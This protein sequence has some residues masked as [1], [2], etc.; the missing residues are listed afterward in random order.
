MQIEETIRDLES[1]RFGFTLRYARTIRPERPEGSPRWPRLFW[2][3]WYLPPLNAKWGGHFQANTE[4]RR[5]VLI[6]VLLG[7][8]LWRNHWFKLTISEL[9]NAL[10]RHKVSIMQKAQY[11]GNRGKLSG[12][13]SSRR[14]CVPEPESHLIGPPH[15]HVRAGSVSLCA[16]HS[17]PGCETEHLRVQFEGCGELFLAQHPRTRGFAVASCPSSATRKKFLAIGVATV[18][19]NCGLLQDGFA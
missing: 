7:Q 10:K 14:R 15:P 12:T 4:R 8:E 11:A 18:D 2:G 5:T 19:C 9:I 6:T 3:W 16:L 1:H 13:P 17:G